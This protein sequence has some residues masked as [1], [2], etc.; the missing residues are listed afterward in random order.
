MLAQYYFSSARFSCALT[1]HSR[2]W[3]NS[4]TCPEVIINL[5]TFTRTIHLVQLFGGLCFESLSSHY[6]HPLLLY[7][8]ETF[9]MLMFCEGIVLSY[10]PQRWFSLI[11]FKADSCPTH[12]ILLYILTLKMLF[13]VPA[14]LVEHASFLTRCV[15]FLWNVSHGSS[16]S[17]L[18]PRA[19]FEEVSPGASQR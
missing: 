15:A 18:L 6:E 2:R 8:R 11:S 12:V 13:F 7:V 14:F 17:W 1:Y 4:Y 5:F 9:A 10:A 16:L 3:S 19:L